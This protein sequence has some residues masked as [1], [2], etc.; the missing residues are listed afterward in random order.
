MSAAPQRWPAEILPLIAI[1]RGIRP[2][3][4]LEVA[5]ALREAGIGAIEVPLNSPSPLGTCWSR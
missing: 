3:E 5:A 4:V 1:L 2:E